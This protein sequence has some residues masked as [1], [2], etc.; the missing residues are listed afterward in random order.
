MPSDA[1][2]SNDEWFRELQKLSATQRRN[3]K[4]TERMKMK[5][6]FLRLLKLLKKPQEADESYLLSGW[7]EPGS[8][9]TE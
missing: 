2:R 1:G 9:R 6:L 3:V 5:K 8:A 7:V 4:T